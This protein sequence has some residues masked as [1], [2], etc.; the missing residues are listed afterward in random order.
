M[1]IPECTVTASSYYHQSTINTIRLEIL[2]SDLEV[3]MQDLLLWH[4]FIRK[5]MFY[6]GDIAGTFFFIATQCA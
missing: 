2:D 6:Q 1:D 5:L 4:P 3:N